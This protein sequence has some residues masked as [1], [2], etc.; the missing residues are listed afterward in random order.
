MTGP[1]IGRQQRKWRDAEG[2]R[3]RDQQSVYRSFT[4]R[5]FQRVER[6]LRHPAD[7]DQRRDSGALHRYSAKWIFISSLVDVYAISQI[8]EIIKNSYFPRNLRQENAA[9]DIAVSSSSSSHGCIPSWRTRAEFGES[10]SILR[11]R[12]SLANCLK[13]PSHL[14]CVKRRWSSNLRTVPGQDAARTK[15]LNFLVHFRVLQGIFPVISAS[16]VIRK[17]NLESKSRV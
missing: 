11:R 7:R 1:Y 5:Y 16:C 2:C 4:W 3:C 9:A 14:Q 17:Q 10:V 13:H 12:Q 15:F 6:H 8:S